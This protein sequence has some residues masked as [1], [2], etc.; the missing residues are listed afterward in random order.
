[1]LEGETGEFGTSKAAANHHTGCVAVGSRVKHDVY[2]PSTPVWVPRFR[3]IERASRRD[4]A[5]PLLALVFAFELSAFLQTFETL[6][7]PQT[8]DNERMAGFKGFEFLK[9]RFRR[10]RCNCA[11]STWCD[12]P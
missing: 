10:R 1:V 11:S 12:T 5:Q 3:W 8:I 9:R 4:R 6:D 7:D 2:A